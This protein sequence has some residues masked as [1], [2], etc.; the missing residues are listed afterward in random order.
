M[1]TDEPFGA[2]AE[3]TRKAVEHLGYVQ[4]DTINVIERC[5]HHILFTRIPAYAR[6]DLRQAHAIDKTVFEY[7]A[8]ALAY[9][10]TKHMPHFVRDMHAH[11][12]R[13]TAV[14]KEEL[15]K[16]LSRIRKHGALSLRDIDDD[17]LVAKDHAWASK[18]PS[19]RALRLAFYQGHLAITERNGILKTYDLASRHSVGSARRVPPASARRLAIYSI[20]PCARRES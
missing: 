5:H 20:V 6:S 18:K 4:I 10:P 14:K 19:A 15:R 16:V 11:R 13:E 8:H 1:D 7:W 3:A 9:L 2:G 12:K 17:E